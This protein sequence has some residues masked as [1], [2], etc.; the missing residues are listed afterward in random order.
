MVVEGGRSILLIRRPQTVAFSSVR[1]CR[2]SAFY[3]RNLLALDASSSPNVNPT[4]YSTGLYEWRKRVDHPLGSR[5]LHDC[6][7]RRRPAKKLLADAGFCQRLAKGAQG[8]VVRKRLFRIACADD[9]YSWVS[10]HGDRRP[11]RCGR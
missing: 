3:C 9:R 1:A 5:E 7:C 11:T 6:S 2:A 10:D 4:G 8:G